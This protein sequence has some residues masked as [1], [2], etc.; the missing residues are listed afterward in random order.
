MPIVF[1][2]VVLGGAAAITFALNR[3]KRK[4]YANLAAHMTRSGIADPGLSNR[5]GDPLV[6]LAADVQAAHQPH[7]Y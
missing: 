4:K 7:S 2:S 1:W 3:R 6:G 5:A